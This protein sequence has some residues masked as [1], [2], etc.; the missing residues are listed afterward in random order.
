MARADG[1]GEVGGGAFGRAYGD[2]SDTRLTDL[3]RADSA[4]AYQ[5]LQELR[6]RHHPS[7]LAYARLCAT[8]ETPARQLAAQ[9][10]TLA[11]RETARGID[12]GVPWRHRLLL[13][14]VREAA[15]WAADAR[16]AGLDPTLLLVLNSTA[17]DDP[18]LPP[19][20]APFQSL[21]PRAQGLLWYGVVEQEPPGRTAAYTG[22]SPEDAAHDTDRALQALSQAC[23]R[24]RLAA[25]TDPHCADFRRLISESVRPDSPRESADLRSH[26]AHCVHC[27]TAHEE[28]SALRDAPPGA[29]V[30]G[31][32]PWAGTS[33]GNRNRDRG[34]DVPEVGTGPRTAPTRPRQP[35]PRRLLLTSAA[36]GVALAPLLAFLLTQGDS[37]SPRESTGA[38][39]AAVSTPPA[40]PP[41]TVTVSPPPTTASA[42]PSPT[43]SRTPSKRPTK[44][45]SAAPTPPPGTAYAQVVNVSSGRCLDIR[46]ADLS[47]G[48]DV[49]TSPCS[50]SP[51]QRWRV[52]S[53]RGA[54]QSYAD[55]DFC[56]D[57]RG[58][59]D[60]GVGIWECASLEGRNAQN[61]RFAVDAAGV[62]RPAVAPDFAVTPGGGG[63]VSLVRETGR[64]D[65]RWRA[66]AG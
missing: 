15:T 52:D 7:V 56:L 17:T 66:G 21:P 46:D 63:S 53:T 61:L 6:A 13:L 36:L 27:T 5:A 38:T 32:L 54:L 16:A 59:T 4:T 62:I 11:A 60:D 43:P 25:S 50:T 10:F 29:L 37:A 40:P 42:S 41:V 8:G 57:S 51:T 31:L 65:Q 3:L 47:K 18:P 49:I 9:A 44:P 23:L 19:L 33:Y 64:A 30:E 39:G 22:L 20:L 14:T 24:S 45:P 12:P 48:T 26:M 1:T 28:L 34:K 35:P 2:A 55:P 58:A